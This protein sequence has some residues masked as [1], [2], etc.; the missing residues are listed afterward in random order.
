[1]PAW[2]FSPRSWR[3]FDL[4]KC[5]CATAFSEGGRPTRASPPSE[6]KLLCD[7]NDRRDAFVSG[8]IVS[9]GLQGMAAVRD[10][11]RIPVKGGGGTGDALEQF[12]IDVQV[13]L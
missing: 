10:F 8:R 7:R 6:S 3:S 9:K 2:F 11:G 1:M 13:D 12:P 4:R 5:L